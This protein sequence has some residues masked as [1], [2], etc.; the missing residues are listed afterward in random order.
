MLDIYPFYIRTSI[1]IFPCWIMSIKNYNIYKQFNMMK[2]NVFETINI[3][4]F[5][6]IYYQ[7]RISILVLIII[8]CLFIDYKF[9][10]CYRLLKFTQLYINMIYDC[11]ISFK[12]NSICFSRNDFSVYRFKNRV[13]SHTYTYIFVNITIIIISGLFDC[14]TYNKNIHDVA[15]TITN[16]NIQGGQGFK[17]ETLY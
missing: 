17:L 12:S 11:K 2:D 14:I 13:W 3:E 1:Y 8:L 5:F 6:N 9:K 16:I 10:S 7:N 4:N 15:D